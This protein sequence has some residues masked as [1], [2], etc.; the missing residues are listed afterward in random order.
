MNQILVLSNVV[1]NVLL[2]MYYAFMQPKSV[3]TKTSKDSMR[4]R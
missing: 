3:R 1:N 2:L 4:V